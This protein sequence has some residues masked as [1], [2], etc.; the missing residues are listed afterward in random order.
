MT[1]RPL[2]RQ[3]F[4][5]ML[6]GSVLGPILF[7]IYTADLASIVAEHDLSL[8]QYVDDS[9]INGSC[10]SD[11]TSS[12]LNTVSQCVHSISN[13]MHLNHL[14]LNAD[15]T[16][17][18]WCSS[19]RK[20]SQLPS[21]SFSV[22]GALL[23]LVNAVPDLVYLSTTT[24]DAKVITIMFWTTFQLYIDCVYHNESTSRWPSWHFVCCM[25][26]RHHP[27]MICPL[28]AD[29]AHRH[30]INCLFHHSGS[31]PLVDTHFQLLHR[32]SGTHC[33]LTSNHP[34]LCPSSVNVLKHSSFISLFL[35]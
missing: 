29:F 17:V 18:M 24:S 34:H 25:V 10:H 8:H 27:R 32:S 14:Q 6:Q 3:M 11:A 2:W 28:V 15:K 22:A 13:W 1:A 16:E 35:T 30:H 4:C 12:L 21:C 19:T 20:L 9:Q 26:S 7:I 5:G 23:C 33:H 31:R